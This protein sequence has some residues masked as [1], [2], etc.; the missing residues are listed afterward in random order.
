[1]IPPFSTEAFGQNVLDLLIP[2]RAPESEDSEPTIGEMTQED[3]AMNMTSLIT[4]I[5]DWR[6]EREM[7]YVNKNLVLGGSTPSSGGA[8][9]DAISMG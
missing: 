9:I 1:M 4:Y 8:A 2:P 7:Q 5:L 6:E 3:F